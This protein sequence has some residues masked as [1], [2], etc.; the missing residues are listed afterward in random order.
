MIW[1]EEALLWFLRRF[2]YVRRM[3][4]EVSEKIRMQDQLVEM[5][6]HLDWLRS[7][8]TEAQKN[9]RLAYQMLVNFETQAKVGIAPFPKAPKLPPA[10]MERLAREPIEIPS[11]RGYDMVANARRRF[12]EQARGEV[13]Q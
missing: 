9:E 2:S 7:Q 13:K 10:T 12:F 8:A 6:G 1:F 11:T 4:S 5:R 3:E